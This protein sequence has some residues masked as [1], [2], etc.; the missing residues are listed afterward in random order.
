M[1]Y[2]L[3]GMKNCYDAAMETAYARKAR[4]ERE[5]KI[6]AGLKK[7]DQGV[8][9]DPRITHKKGTRL[10]GGTDTGVTE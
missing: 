8:A 2:A 5:Q 3:K 7:G 4:T 9:R 1:Y 6:A 10:M